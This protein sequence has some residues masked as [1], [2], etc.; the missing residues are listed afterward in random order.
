VILFLNHIRRVDEAREKMDEAKHK[1]LET[2]GA[3][4]H[5]FQ[6]EL[7]QRAENFQRDFLA[8]S[9]VMFAKT[10]EVLTKNVE[11]TGRNIVVLE[12]VEGLIGKHESIHKKVS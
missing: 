3:G 6:K 8:R 1:A 7:A 2:L 9:E 5:G 12:K 11:M 10:A 4:C